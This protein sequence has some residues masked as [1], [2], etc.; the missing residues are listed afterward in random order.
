LINWDDKQKVHKE[1]HEI[2]MSPEIKG[3]FIKVTLTNEAKEI[4]KNKVEKLPL[5]LEI[6]NIIQKVFYELERHII[7][8]NNALETQWFLKPLNEDYF[9]KLFPLS[10]GIQLF[11]TI[12]EKG[13]R[14]STKTSQF[15]IDM[16]GHSLFSRFVNDE[17]KLN[18]RLLKI[19]KTEKVHL[20]ILL[21]D[22]DKEL[23][24]SCEIFDSQKKKNEMRS[25]LP[26]YD[27]KYDLIEKENGDIFQSLDIISDRWQNEIGENSC[28]KVKLTKKILY[29]SIM[30]FGGQMIVTPYT[31]GLSSQSISIVYS[32]ESPIYDA[33]LNDFELLWDKKD[34][35]RLFLSKAGINAI[36]D[37]P[38]KDIIPDEYQNNNKSNF[39]YE[40]WLLKKCKNRIE[41]WFENENTI[42]PPYEL[43]IQ[44][45][46]TCNLNCTHCIGRHLEYLDLKKSTLEVKDIESIKTLL[47]WNE[48]GFKIERLRISGLNGDPLSDAALE[49]TKTIILR[50][51]TDFKREIVLFTNGLNIDKAINEL[52][53]IDTLH[54][55]ID[56]GS[57]ET[58]KAMKNSK[59]FD[60]IFEN[61]RKLKAKFK[62][63][64]EHPKI[65]FGYVV[66][67]RNYNE[68]EMILDE[69][70]KEGIDFIR[71]KRDIHSPNSISWRSW[72]EAK[73]K[74]EKIIYNKNN[75][76]EDYYPKIDNIFITDLPRHHW[77]GNT[78]NCISHKYCLT[79]GA[80]KNVYT[81]DHLT[82]K[83]YTAI[84][85]FSDDDFN[86]DN[87]RNKLI[88]MIKKNIEN[89]NYCKKLTNCSQC[90]PFNY[91]FNYFLP[92]LESLYSKGNW[93]KFEKKLDSYV[94]N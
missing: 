36:D 17:E 86:Q 3:D 72:I 37:N 34:E 7:K 28:L 4:V 79:V 9:G 65:G 82:S 68:V 92:Q 23:Q 50:N 60:K 16:L 57:K 75:K 20:R 71:F 27:K 31:M 40:N 63:N 51:Q 6:L 91:R 41:F 22:P 35:T 53:L 43:E 19:L 77:N 11:N 84:G 13:F 45:T 64:Q 73:D 38:I 39:N 26:L 94:K 56:A 69:A 25:I 14:E 87:S 42:I 2:I 89:K 78:K 44:P 48:G 66:T 61:I 54:I 81:C 1:K 24:Q 5:R 10:Y 55:S 88:K 59:D 70:N 8:L 76:N 30:R 58:F 67:Q 47:D 15:E 29:A 21:L 32:K 85:S 49:F 12:F 93:S 62:H 18:D 74:I 46:N 33:F 80:D 90:P 52:L 83:A